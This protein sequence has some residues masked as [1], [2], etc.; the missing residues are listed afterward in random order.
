ME[1]EMRAVDVCRSVAISGNAGR[2]MSMA[3]GLRVESAPR[4]MI[5]R[6]RFREGVIKTIERP[7]LIDGATLDSNGKGDLHWNEIARRWPGSNL[8]PWLWLNSRSL[9]CGGSEYGSDRVTRRARVVMVKSTYR[10]KVLT[11]L[12]SLLIND[13]SPY[14][15]PYIFRKALTSLMVNDLSPYINVNVV[16][17][18]ASFGAAPPGGAEPL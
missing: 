17:V 2:Y 14:T 18:F 6:W 13:L 3:N 7:T 15:T 12:T 4:M 11:L 16:P 8:N 10:G 5:M 9:I 1:R